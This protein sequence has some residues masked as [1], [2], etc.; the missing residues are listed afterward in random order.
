MMGV[1]ESIVAHAA[2]A[3]L[4]IVGYLDLMLDP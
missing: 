2:M 1:A 4:E 3:W